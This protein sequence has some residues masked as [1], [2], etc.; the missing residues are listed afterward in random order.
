MAVAVSV[1]FATFPTMPNWCP[2]VVN[3]LGRVDGGLARIRIPGGRMTAAQLAAVSDAAR[4]RGADLIEITNRANLQLRGIDASRVGGLDAELAAARL[5]AG[6]AGD[7]RRNI[8]VSPLAGLD[9]TE[10]ADVRALV[11]PLLAR[12]DG[13]PRLDDLSAKYGVILDGGGRWHLGGRRDDAVVTAV[14]GAPGSGDAPTFEVRVGGRQVRTVTAAEVPDVLCDAALASLGR[15]AR[16]LVAGPAG[17]VDRPGTDRA[18]GPIGIGTQ[19]DPDRR[20]VGAMPVLGRMDGATSGAVAALAARYA[21]GWV[22]LTPWRGLVLGDVAA[23]EA[24]SVLVALDDLG[25]LTAPADPGAAVFACAGARGCTSGLTDA[26]GDALAVID[27]RRRQG[28]APLRVHVSGCAKRCAQHDPAPVTL[29]GVGPD[30]YDVFVADRDAPGGERR[31]A[32]AVPGSV[33]MIAAAAGGPVGAGP[34]GAGPV[35]AGPVGAGL[36]AEAGR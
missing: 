33:A 31:S 5:S 24:R 34:V 11:A 35:G 23:R 30:R 26:P 20:W 22:A 3:V 17:S 1:R 32:V 12:L 14:A 18:V 15:P 25:L 4:R 27:A 28:S 29:I 10:V 9:P 2:S 6:A 8:L 36:V 19:P 16:R 13:E 7:L 21:G